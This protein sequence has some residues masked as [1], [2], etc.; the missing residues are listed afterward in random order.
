MTKKAP[1]TTGKTTG[2]Y[3]NKALARKAAAAT[4]YRK[5]VSGRSRLYGAKG[6]HPTTPQDGAGV[7]KT[8]AQARDEKADLLWTGDLSLILTGSDK[9]FLRALAADIAKRRS[10][11]APVVTDTGTPEDLAERALST[12][13]KHS[14]LAEDTGPFYDTP[15]LKKWLDVSRQ[16]LDNRVKEGTLLMCLTSD[17]KR[18]Y[19]AWQFN[20]KGVVIPGIAE[21][22]KTFRDVGLEPGWAVAKWLNVPNPDLGDEKASSL[23]AE[24]NVDAVLTA[25]R[26]DAERMSH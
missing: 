14:R 24:G 26:R 20:H 12:L 1:K 7:S 16:R 8:R 15:S 22:I 5:K 10:K 11:G 6:A 25:A 9:N 18:V 23:L 2:Y 21:V 3:T 4:A 17:G 13:P 19:P